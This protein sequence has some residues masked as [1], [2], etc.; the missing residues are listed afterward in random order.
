MSR[1]TCRVRPKVFAASPLRMSNIPLTPGRQWLMAQ[2]GR[3]DRRGDLIGPSRKASGRAGRFCKASGA[4]V[5]AYFSFPSNL[6]F[7]PCFFTNPNRSCR[8]SSSEFNSQTLRLSSPNRR[9]KCIRISH[10]SSKHKLT[11]KVFCKLIFIN[12]TFQ[13]ARAESHRVSSTHKQ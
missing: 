9:E 1:P 12:L 6:F 7:L 10:D 3:A 13:I 11:T 2:C 4:Y 8:T 5:L